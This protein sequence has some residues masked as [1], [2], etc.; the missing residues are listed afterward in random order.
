MTETNALTLDIPT[1]LREG[2][3]SKTGTVRLAGVVASNVVVTLTSS[4]TT[5]AHGCRPS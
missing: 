5:D 2:D 3:A 4:D 1:A